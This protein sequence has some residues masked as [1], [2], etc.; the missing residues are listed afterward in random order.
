MTT[1]EFWSLLW[2]NGQVLWGPRPHTRNVRSSSGFYWHTHPAAFPRPREGVEQKDCLANS[3]KKRNW[4]S[5]LEVCVCVCVVDG[6][7]TRVRKIPIGTTDRTHTH[8]HSARVGIP[9]H[10]FA[11]RV[12]EPRRVGERKPPRAT[13]CVCVLNIFCQNTGVVP[14]C[15]LKNYTQR[16][17]KRMINCKKVKRS[18]V[19]I[20]TTLMY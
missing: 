1:V 8:T 6:E 2:E 15:T 12:Q 16:L 5:S 13:S 10:P 19:G 14:A 20:L 4:R 7:F 3:N 9:V 18:I 11:R 17:K